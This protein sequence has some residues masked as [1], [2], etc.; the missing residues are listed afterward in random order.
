M[1][2]LKLFELRSFDGAHISSHQTFPLALIS[3]ARLAKETA[4][5]I[6]VEIWDVR[7][8]N[9]PKLVATLNSEGIDDPH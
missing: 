7:R 8:Y 4:G 2:E 6:Q 9:I 1:S 5:Y 3:A